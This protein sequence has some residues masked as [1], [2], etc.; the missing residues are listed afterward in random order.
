MDG[1]YQRP[2][3]RASWQ[4]IGLAA[5]TGGDVLSLPSYEGIR[6]DS[7]ILAAALGRP[8]F[9]TPRRGQLQWIYV[10]LL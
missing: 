3:R 8:G 9:L 2:A 4:W 1:H 10:S 5:A 6:N 7:G